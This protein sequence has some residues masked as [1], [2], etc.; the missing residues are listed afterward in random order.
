M[1]AVRIESRS[2]PDTE[3]QVVADEVNTSP[4][5]PDVN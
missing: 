2:L 3:K 5:P 1:A 4:K